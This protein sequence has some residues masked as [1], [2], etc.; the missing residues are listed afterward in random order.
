[1][2]LKLNTPKMPA[3]QKKDVRMTFIMVTMWGDASET[4]KVLLPWLGSIIIIPTSM[5][6]I[7]HTVKFEN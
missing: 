5:I 4:V 1:M 6:I 2:T 7:F 3:I